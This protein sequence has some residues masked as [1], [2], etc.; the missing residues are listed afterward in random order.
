MTK[1]IHLYFSHNWWLIFL[2][3]VHIERSDVSKSKGSQVCLLYEHSWCFLPWSVA[4]HLWTKSDI[5]LSQLIYN[6]IKWHRL[7][8]PIKL[9]Y[10]WLWSNGV[11]SKFSAKFN[12]WTY[13]IVPIFT[14]ILYNLCCTWTCVFGKSWSNIQFFLCFGKFL[15]S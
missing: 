5:Y 4:S 12:C 9:L 13:V 14:K 1:T 6:I 2:V 10:E 8:A 11:G 3:L 15:S 7:S